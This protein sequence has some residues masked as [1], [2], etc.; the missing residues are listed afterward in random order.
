MY[1]LALGARV[2]I[3]KIPLQIASQSQDIVWYYN[4]S[5]TKYSSAIK[6]QN[7]LIPIWH[8][9]DKAKMGEF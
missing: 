9:Y 8:Y 1:V 3:L 2:V 4:R 7:I 6:L 5:H